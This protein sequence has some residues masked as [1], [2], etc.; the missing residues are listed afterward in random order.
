VAVRAG[1]ARGHFL[2]SCRIRH[3]ERL[4]RPWGLRSK[5]KPERAAVGRNSERALE[6]SAESRAAPAVI[7]EEATEPASS[8]A[9]AP[10]R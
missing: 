10:S 9:S 1:P 6:S 3:V 2:A 7:R 5:D 8:G 4:V